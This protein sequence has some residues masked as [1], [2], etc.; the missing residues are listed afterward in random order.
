VL[1]QV[2][3]AES[4]RKCQKLLAER[5]STAPPYPG[6]KLRVTVTTLF[7]CG[8]QQARGEEFCLAECPARAAGAFEYVRV[9]HE[10]QRP[11]DDPSAVDVGV[12]DMNHGW[13]NIGHDAIVMGIQTMACDIREELRAAGLRVRAVSYDVRRGGVIPHAPSPRFA[14]GSGGS[15]GSNDSYAND[16]GVFVGT[17][18]PGHLDPRR[19]DGVSPG[20]QTIAENPAWEAPLFAWFDAVRAHPGAALLGICHTFGVMCRWLRLAEPVLRGAEKGGKSAGV[21]DN[22]LTPAASAHPWFQ[23]MIAESPD[24]PRIRI[25]DNRL[26]D[27]IPSEDARVRPDIAILSRETHGPGGPPGDS[28]TMIEVARDA[29]G[30]MPRML[31]VNHH[32]EIVNRTRVLMVL[33]QKRARGEVTHQ[34]YEERARAM[35][36]TLQDED[37]DRRLDLTSRYTLVEPLRFHLYRQ[38][39]LRAERLGRPVRLHEDR[40]MEAAAVSK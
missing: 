34:W 19:N 7:E 6:G 40:V 21:I 25:L 11:P 5:S 16:G 10:D 30:V 33:W 26:Y 1:A 38:I 13:P 35:T 39:R 24:G 9:E 22:L 27:L 37:S 20:S 31:A 23:R 12:L 4:L 32:P 14:N 18:G 15:A 2:S 8:P 17:G 3:D 29:N 36:Q 28:L